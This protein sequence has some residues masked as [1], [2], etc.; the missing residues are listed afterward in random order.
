MIF[1]TAK[2]EVVLDGSPTGI[3]VFQ[4]YGS[5]HVHDNENKKIAMP[6]IDYAIDDL[7]ENLKHLETDL[8]LVLDYNAMVAQVRLQADTIRTL[9]YRLSVYRQLKCIGETT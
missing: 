1:I 4:Y 6:R 8:K 5:T 3:K 7:E 2:N 9:R